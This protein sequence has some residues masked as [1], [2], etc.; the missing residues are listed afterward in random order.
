MLSNLGKPRR[1]FPT[2]RGLS[3]W[4]KHSLPT[5]A[6]PL[7]QW[8][9][10]TQ[11]T[12]HPGRASSQGCNF[13]ISELQQNYHTWLKVLIPKP[14][15]CFPTTFVLQSS[16]FWPQFSRR[17]L[18]LGRELHIFNLD[19]RRQLHTLVTST[20][21]FDNGYTFWSF[22]PWFSTM[23]LHTL[24]T[25]TIFWTTVTPFGH[26]HFDLRRCSYTLWWLPPYFGQRLHRLV[27]STLIFDDAVVHFGDF[28]F[29]VRRQL[30]SLTTLHLAT[31]YNNSWT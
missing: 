12:F 5:H 13:P 24:V 2:N 17:L 20:L 14:L 1:K 10:A 7:P 8:Q 27:T 23:Q 18:D 3:V 4:E 28:H 30:H 16:Q 11:K 29:D 21:T 19:F 25:S 6:F 26:F 31:V 22:P 15:G 9:G